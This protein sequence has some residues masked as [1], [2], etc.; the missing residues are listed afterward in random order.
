MEVCGIEVVKDDLQPIHEIR[1]THM[2]NPEILFIVGCREC[3]YGLPLK[4]VIRTNLDD[5][6]YVSIIFYAVNSCVRKIRI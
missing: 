3:K 2:L 5:K 6:C 4:I 1:E